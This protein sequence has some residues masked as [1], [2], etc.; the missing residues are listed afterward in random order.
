MASGTAQ[1]FPHFGNRVA[2]TLPYTADSDGLLIVQLRASATG[3]LYAIWSGTFEA[4]LDGY[5]V[6]DGYIVGTFPVQKGA[7][8]S[9][10]SSS[11]NVQTA[12]YYWVSFNN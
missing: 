8:V 6:K 12:G 2:I 5:N 3:R 10:P 4:F 11:S 7:V 9:A 1:M